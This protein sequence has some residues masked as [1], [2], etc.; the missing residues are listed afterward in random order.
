[1][2]AHQFSKIKFQNISLKIFN[3]LI[4]KDWR[5]KVMWVISV[6]KE[7]SGEESEKYRFRPGEYTIGR[8]NTN[9]NLTD[10]S[11]SR[12]HA[13]IHVVR[14][15]DDELKKTK[16]YVS[17][18]SKFGVII[19]G[20]KMESNKSKLEVKEG[21]IITFGTCKTEFKVEFEPM[22]VYWNDKDVSSQHSE[23][24]KSILEQVGKDL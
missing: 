5:E 21:S 2:I 17:D 15:L 12:T 18:N 1:M 10:K 20:V 8:L 6:K 9:I 3:E 22:L 11:V 19:D 23:H 24:L 13:T 16:M 7:G 4:K 14:I